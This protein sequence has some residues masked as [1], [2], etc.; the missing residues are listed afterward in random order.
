MHCL[1]AC[2]QQHVESVKIGL[3]ALAYNAVA[4]RTIADRDGPYLG[5]IVT[6]SKE[7]TLASNA[8]V[9]RSPAPAAA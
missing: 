7:V 6:P 5:A 4:D 2:S 1:K 3:C 8:H 9:F